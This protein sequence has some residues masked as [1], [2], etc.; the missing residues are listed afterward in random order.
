MG[1]VES[2]LMVS[3]STI[4]ALQGRMIDLAGESL[5][6]KEVAEKLTAAQAVTFQ[7]AHYQKKTH[8]LAV[9][10]RRRD[11]SCQGQSRGLQGRHC[12]TR[13]WGVPLTSLISRLLSTATCILIQRKT[14]KWASVSMPRLAPTLGVPNQRYQKLAPHDLSR[15]CARCVTLQVANWIKSDFIW[16]KSPFKPPSI[17]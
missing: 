3:A 14:S 4:G 17:T 11:E 12:A 1:K 9:S 7:F 5:T 10:T 13:A 8:L 15:T 2:D 6:M 16:D